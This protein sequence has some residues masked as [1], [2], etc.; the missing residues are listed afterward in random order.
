MTSIALR[1]GLGLLIAAGS[2]LQAS[3]GPPG[4]LPEFVRSPVRLEDARDARRVDSAVEVEVTFEDREYRILE[5]IPIKYVIKNTSEED[6]WQPTASNI[7]NIIDVNAYLYGFLVSKTEYT[8]RSGDVGG[9]GTSVGGMFRPGQS[10]R[11]ELLANLSS[12]MTMPGEYSVFVQMRT[13]RDVEIDGKKYL[14]VARSKEMKVRVAPPWRL[15]PSP[16]R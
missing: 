11:G 12:D 3:P 2:L 4:K 5:P 7:Y 9:S 15:P 1:R 8:R 10:L 6:R 13:G 16:S 14:I